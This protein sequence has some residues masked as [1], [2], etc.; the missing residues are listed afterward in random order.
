VAAENAV[1]TR[2]GAGIGVYFHVPGQN[3]EAVFVKTVGFWKN[4]LPRGEKKYKKQEKRGASYS[5]W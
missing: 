1:A 3:R 4:F 2:E 5:A